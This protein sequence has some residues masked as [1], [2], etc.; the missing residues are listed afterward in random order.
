MSCFV[1]EVTL[2][3]E[4]VNSV[5]QGRLKVAASSVQPRSPLGGSGLKLSKYVCEQPEDVFSR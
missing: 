2:K 4:W 5:P 3:S 1:E